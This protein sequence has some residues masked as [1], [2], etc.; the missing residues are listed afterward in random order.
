MVKAACFI[1]STTLPTW[2]DEILC[3][4]LDYLIQRPIIDCLDFIFINNTG[5]HLNIPKIESLHPKIRVVNY[6]TDPSTFEIS[7]IR[8]M[9]SF[10]KLHPDY[11]LL[12]LHTKGISRPKDCI[13][14]N[15]VR[16]WVDFMLYCTV[17]KCSTCL[18]LLDVYNTVGPNEMSVLSPGNPPHY[19]GN[20]WWTTASYM[21]TR[22]DISRLKDKFDPEFF[23]IGTRQY[24]TDYFSVLEL[25]NLYES[26]YKQ[27]TYTPLVENRLQNQV[28]YCRLD[29]FDVNQ[30]LPLFTAFMMASVYPGHTIIILDND[31]VLQSKEVLC[32]VDEM[33]NIDKTNQSLKPYN[34]TLIVRSTVKMTVE[35]VD[36]G[37]QPTNIVS[38]S[39]DFIQ[40]H[41]KPNYFSIPGSVDLN[42]LANVEDPILFTRKHLYITY[43]INDF[44]LQTYFD[45]VITLYFHYMKMDFVDYSNVVWIDH[46]NIM[47]NMKVKETVKK[48]VSTM[49]L[50][51]T[52][53]D[54][55]ITEFLESMEYT[56]TSATSSTTPS[57]LISPLIS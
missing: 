48:M 29:H 26:T 49:H 47:I 20:Y 38:L 33:L 8:Q 11:K 35:K 50:S 55:W 30:F 17:D 56:P 10:A 51:L 18:Q 45:E 43:K 23:I 22:L 13:T 16:S 44:V 14:R 46:S 31:I 32:R 21:I 53:E 34:I 57:V 28:L 40:R 25:Y 9:Y 54:R 52:I 41:H 37:V 5:N 4:L 12:Y 24:C 39:D 19:S 2:E 15:P 27:E 1:H 36:W 42:A 7:T 6:S 3:Y